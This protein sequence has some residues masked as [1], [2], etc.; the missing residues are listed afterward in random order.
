MIK[1]EK[2]NK[3]NLDKVYTKLVKIFQEAK[4]DVRDILTIYGNLGYTLGASI[5]GYQTKGP[6]IEELNHLYATNP[7]VDVALMIQ[8]INTVLWAEDLGK[9]IES[10][11]SKNAI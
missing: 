10:I 3:K 4:L 2:A 8:S 11:K 5:G 9:T 1:I 6:N 7:T